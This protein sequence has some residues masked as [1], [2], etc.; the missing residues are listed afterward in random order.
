MT[1]LAKNIFD[2]GLLEASASGGNTKSQVTQK[3]ADKNNVSTKLKEKKSFDIS[4]R[5]GDS[6]RSKLTSQ[7]SSEEVSE[8]ISEVKSSG[9]SSISEENKPLNQV[10]MFNETDIS[11]ESVSDDMEVLQ[12]V[13]SIDDL[14]S[15]TKFS[16]VD[17]KGKPIA[18]PKSILSTTPRQNTPRSSRSHVRLSFSTLNEKKQSR[19]PSPEAISTARGIFILFIP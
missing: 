1:G 14:P 12:N 10:K 9:N 17:N 8:N 2:I 19:S 3:T 11:D 15:H 7:Y 16:E 13:H 6:T 4:T 5:Y 18:T